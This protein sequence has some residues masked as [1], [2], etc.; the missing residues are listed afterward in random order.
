MCRSAGKAYQTVNIQLS[1]DACV[2]DSRR[3]EYNSEILYTSS[4]QQRRSEI[5]AWA[6][7]DSVVRAKSKRDQKRAMPNQNR[8]VLIWQG[9]FGKWGN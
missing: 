5:A 2:E 7:Y 8:S 6:L 3:F 1:L 9:R 4:T